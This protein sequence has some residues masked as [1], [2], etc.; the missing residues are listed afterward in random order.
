M[1][2]GRVPVSGMATDTRDPAPGRLGTPGRSGAPGRSWLSGGSAVRGLVVALG[3]L[4]CLYVAAGRLAPGHGPML[5]RTF[6]WSVNAGAVLALVLITPRRQVPLLL[7]LV[8]VLGALVRL[9]TDPVPVAALVGLSNVP[10]VAA[11]RALALR[12]AE[13]RTA[14]L[15]RR[16]LLG[17]FGSG[18]AAIAV[19]A[20]TAEVALR[21]GA[22]IGGVP[23]TAAVSTSFVVG[24][25]PLAQ[26]DGLV[27]VLPLV[28]LLTGR[29]PASWSRR[30]WAE[31][32]G[33]LVGLAAVGLLALEL[34]AAVPLDPLLVLLA[35]AALVLAVLRRG[36]LAAAVLCPAFAVTVAGMLPGSLAGE[37]GPARAT[38]FA[39]PSGQ[40][41]ALLAGVLAWS[42]ASVVGERD[43]A[44]RRAD[45][46]TAARQALTA[47][48]T[49]LLPAHVTSQRDVTVAA[50]YRAAGVLDQIGGDWY[51]TIALPGGG[52][53]IVIGDVEGHDLTAASV[54]GLVRGA[55]RSY[56]LEGHPPS[57]VL[58]RLAAFLPS[59]GIDRLVT[60]AYVQLAA[61]DRTAVV[62]LAGHPSPLLVPATGPASLLECR[63]GPLMGVAGLGG[64]PEE[65][66]SLP[67]GAC[68][69]LYTDGLVDYPSTGR[70]QPPDLVDVASRLADRDVDRLADT[71]IGVASSYDDAAVL[72]ARPAPTPDAPAERI[73]PARPSSAGIARVWLGD[74]YAVRHAAGLVRTGPGPD[75]L[76]TAKL[77][78]TE[79][80]SNAVRHS[81]DRISVRLDL[82]EAL[83][84]VEVEDTSERMPVLRHQ[85]DAA[86]EG[87]GLRLVDAMA[88][89]WGVRLV[90]RGKAVWFELTLLG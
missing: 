8:A 90:E 62:A 15:G 85:E 56:A 80:V 32:A 39:V 27:T 89:A 25:R 26:C 1:A 40:A 35:F 83:L 50:R 22:A 66:V 52:L 86:S 31:I 3:L 45:A 69:V 29:R 38:A 34:P 12:F 43:E 58:E 16:R 67:A 76:D 81:D 61:H 82:R 88:D 70:D 14:P 41:A 71:L 64:W 72:V 7:V 18:L 9:P 2:Q 87:R 73:L 28:L 53:G 48:Q 75:D 13:D 6:S 21:L 33:W 65:T 77:L 60:M 57:V 46:E 44:R 30:A 51:D 11:F 84:R 37:L 10:A 5:Q 54:M 4:T 74:V 68:L 47:L 55:V 78:L 17:L 23:R 19:G 79:L 20:V 59:A 49:A 24:W 36:E 42:V 63:R